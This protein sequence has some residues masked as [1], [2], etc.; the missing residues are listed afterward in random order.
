M[1]QLFCI[2]DE[3]GRA[4]LIK[5]SPLDEIQPPSF[6]T[7]GLLVSL[8]TY[9]ESAGYYVESFGTDNVRIVYRRFDNH[10]MAVLATNNML[11]SG[12]ALDHMLQTVY[13]ALQLLVGAPLLASDNSAHGDVLRK[14]LRGLPLIEQLIEDDG[15]V[16]S[17]LLPGPQVLG[18]P[19]K[20]RSA[21]VRSLSS[22]AAAAGTAHAALLTGGLYLAASPA[23]WQ[24]L[25]GESKVLQHM[26]THMEPQVPWVKQ[27]EQPVFL[28]LS[29][30][31]QPQRLLA[32]PLHPGVQLLLLLP[33]GAEVQEDRL[34]SS[35]AHHT[36]HV[37]FIFK[38]P[39]WSQP[40]VPQ[41]ASLAF[42]LAAVV[43]HPPQPRITLFWGE[44]RA[45]PHAFNPLVSPTVRR[46]LSST[47]PGGS[48]AWRALDLSLDASQQ[49]SPQLFF[50]ASTDLVVAFMLLTPQLHQEAG[51]MTL[52][53]ER[54]GG[55]EEQ[56]AGE[57]TAKVAEPAPAL[58]PPPVRTGVAARLAASL[59]R[60]CFRPDAREAA[61]AGKRLVAL[62]DTEH[63][64][65][66]VFVCGSS[67]SN[68]REAV[69]TANKLRS[70]FCMS[71]S[72]GNDP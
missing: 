15:L 6:P 40:C 39:L 11:V 33:L 67:K 32:V 38:Q 36:Q 24:L 62:L 53:V 68:R 43:Q 12:Q 4:L 44:G 9:S 27:A 55:E 20:E 3:G 8:S 17:L 71:Y 34:M 60:D 18:L 5:T 13:A 2:L 65:V 59:L 64:G 29:A 35:I 69:E 1:P 66:S 30:Y 48:P 31:C 45:A 26:V 25:P 49:A 37:E 52:G 14:R 21:L 56:L 19:L 46:Q 10:M 63:K 23:W 28:S 51:S 7:V 72:I 47:G 57:E 42:D 22:V 16:P 54:E 61:P 50:K 70:I 41:F 58:P